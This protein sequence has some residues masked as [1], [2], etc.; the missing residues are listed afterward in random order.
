MTSLTYYA[1]DYF[2]TENLFS[3]KVNVEPLKWSK[4]PGRRDMNELTMRNGSPNLEQQS[5]VDDKQMIG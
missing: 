5:F 1:V 4:S 3:T 2:R